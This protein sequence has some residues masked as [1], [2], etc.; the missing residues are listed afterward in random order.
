M[1]ATT[2]QNQ[3]TKEFQGGISGARRFEQPF[4]T[5]PVQAGDFSNITP[6]FGDYQ[7]VRRVYS[8]KR[9]KLYQLTQLGLIRSVSLR[10]PGQKFAKRLWHM[11]SIRNYLH[12]LM[13]K[14]TE[15]MAPIAD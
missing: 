5:A 8:L 1:N 14:Q 3:I 2:I 6:E 15:P 13:Q 7:A 10:R 4:T 12:G 9:G 11:E